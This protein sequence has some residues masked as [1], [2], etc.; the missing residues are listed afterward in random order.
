MGRISSVADV[1][2][3]AKNGNTTCQINHTGISL[4]VTQNPFRIC[5]YTIYVVNPVHRLGPKSGFMPT[6]VTIFLD[7]Q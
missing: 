3:I 2:Y 6:L 7:V 4:I 1:V 5:D